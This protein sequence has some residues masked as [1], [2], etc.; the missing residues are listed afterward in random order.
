MKDDKTALWIWDEEFVGKIV[1]K[2]AIDDELLVL[3]ISVTGCREDAFHSMEDISPFGVVMESNL[4]EGVGT[5]D[6]ERKVGV[7]CSY[8]CEDSEVAVAITV[9]FV[10][11]FSIDIK[12]KAHKLYC[13]LPLKK[14]LFIIHTHIKLSLL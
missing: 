11:L 4:E 8:E 14:M 9:G 2:A 13:S 7:V 12:I 10:Y 6:D 3:F 5:K 1:D